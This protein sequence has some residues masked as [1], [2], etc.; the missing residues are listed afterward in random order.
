MNPPNLTREGDQPS[1]QNQSHAEDGRRRQQERLSREEAYYQFINDLS[2]DDYRLMRDR[3]LLGTPGEITAEELQQRLDEAKER[4]TSQPNVQNDVNAGEGNRGSGTSAENSNSDSLLEWLNTF[5]RTGNST[6]SGQS[7]NQTWRAISRTNPNSGEF[8]FSLEININHEQHDPSY[9]TANE[10][11]MDYTSAESNRNSSRSEVTSS[12]QLSPVRITRNRTQYDISSE[13]NNSQRTRPRRRPE[14]R[15]SNEILSSSALRRLRSRNGEAMRAT[16]RHLQGGQTRNSVQRRTG[17]IS[18]AQQRSHGNSNITAERESNCISSRVRRTRTRTTLQQ[19]GRSQRTSPCR[20]RSTQNS[21]SRSPLQRINNA[22][23]SEEHS[24]QSPGIPVNQS[25]TNPSNSI[26]EDQSAST[27]EIAHAVDGSQ[28]PDQLVSETASGSNPEETESNTSNGPSVAVRRHPTIMLDLQVR[29]IR[30]GESRD[31]DSI[32]SRTRSRARMA[33]NTVT[34]ESNSGGFRRT[35]SRSEREGIRTYVSTIRIPLRRISETGPRLPTS[36]ALR[37]IFR[38][39]MTGF[40]ELNTLMEMESDSEAQRGNR[41]SYISSG[42]R[43]S[44]NSQANN[45]IVHESNSPSFRSQMREQSAAHE[46]AP[47]LGQSTDNRDTRQSQDAHNVVENGTLPILRLAHFFLLNE[48]EDDER[49]RGLT[50]EQIDNLPT[51]NYGD[52][53]LECEISKTCSVCINE[54]AAGNKLKRLPCA[55]EFHIHCIDRWLSE[56]STCPICRQRVSRS[57]N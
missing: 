57:D 31:R 9:E 24:Q 6:R 15:N 25:H 49:P 1:V 2:E 45:T 52:C 30:P 34:F 17:D 21:R 11:P 46:V 33:E 4:L 32:A 29:R 51:R 44:R 55:H 8:R 35:I 19:R 7:G 43:N 3:N 40:G 20:F 26:S 38:Q 5:R 47:S 54:Y 28:S 39:I 48:D 41:H 27:I 14:G 18:A 23:T 50:K 13:S 22:S 12:P 10:E 37:S 56:N 36:V 16:R 53:S 42:I